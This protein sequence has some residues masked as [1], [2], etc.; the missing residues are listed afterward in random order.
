MTSL[1]DTLRHL[2]LS[3][4]YE[5]LTE[6]GFEDWNTVLDITED[7]LDHLGFKLGHR[8]LLQREIATYCAHRPVKSLETQTSNPVYLTRGFATPES[9]PDQAPSSPTTTQS[10]KDGKRRYRRHPRPDPNAPKKPKTAYVNFSDH[11]RRDARISALSFVEI[12]REVGRQWQHMDPVLK[13]NW[14]RH[15]AKAMQEYESAMDDYKQTDG[16]RKYQVYV[17]EFRAQERTRQHRR[18]QAKNAAAAAAASSSTSMSTTPRRMDTPDSMEDSDDSGTSPAQSID[19]GTREGM[20]R[21]QSV[22]SAQSGSSRRSN[23]YSVL[24]QPP[25]SLLQPTPPL[26]SSSSADDR[27]ETTRSNSSKSSSSTGF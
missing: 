15:A 21:A 19:A 24:L 10:G 12:A 22:Q 20:V 9:L 8:R 11:L 16:W 6:N 25:P 23:I 4:Y 7:D 18:Q 26:S 3:Q 2:G 14:E 1:S 27:P 17:D 13:S 5:V